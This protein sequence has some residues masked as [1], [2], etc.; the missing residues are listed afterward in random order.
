MK[1]SILFLTLIM[2][3][4]NSSDN[5]K[6]AT[7]PILLVTEDKDNTYY[8]MK[9]VK[10]ILL[11]TYDGEGSLDCTKPFD[12]M[13][14]DPVLNPAVRHAVHLEQCNKDIYGGL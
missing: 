8:E 14:L 9:W 1:K 2:V 6:Y 12:D 7:C 3:L 4:F 10:C 13:G 11:G 5:L